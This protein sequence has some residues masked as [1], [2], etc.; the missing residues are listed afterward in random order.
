[1]E[2][3]ACDDAHVY[4]GELR[5]PHGDDGIY[6]AGET[7][8]GCGKDSDQRGGRCARDCDCDGCRDRTVRSKRRYSGRP[9]Y[10]FG[11]DEPARPPP[12]YKNMERERAPIN[13]GPLSYY[14]RPPPYYREQPVHEARYR[15]DAPSYRGDAS[16]HGGAAYRSEATYD[17]PRVPYGA[18]VTQSAPPAPTVAACPTCDSDD[19]LRSIRIVLLFIV[20][21]LAV[22]AATFARRLDEIAD[23]RAEGRS[24]RASNNT[25]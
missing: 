3:A 7:A 19:L 15:G 13:R 10:E 6:I 5:V 4:P 9:D 18:V 8:A 24:T 14:G 1:M 23:Q 11:A 16:Y 21:M 17:E 20:V 25:S 22:M 2:W 12:Y